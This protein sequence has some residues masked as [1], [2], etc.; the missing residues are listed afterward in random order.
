[1]DLGIIYNLLQKVQNLDEFM[2]YNNIISQ[3]SEE[4][5]LMNSR[6]CGNIEASNKVKVKNKILNFINSKTKTIEGE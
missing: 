6:E 1:M 2:L 5:E 3:V 4:N